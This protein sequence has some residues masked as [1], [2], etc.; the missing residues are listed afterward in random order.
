LNENLNSPKE[1]SINITWALI[2]NVKTM[3]SNWITWDEVQLMYLIH[4][5]SIN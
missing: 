5:W 1:T 2:D 4:H 3:T